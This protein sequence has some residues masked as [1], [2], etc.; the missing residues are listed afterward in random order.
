[1]KHYVAIGEAS[2]WIG[3]CIK[4]L[5]R[6]DQDGKIHYYRTLGGH[7]RF[8]LIEIERIISGDLTEEV[9][10]FGMSESLS[11]S[12][13]AIYARVSSHEQKKKGDL[14][15]QIE[16][17]K[18]YCEERGASSPRVFTDVSSGLNTKRSGLMRLFDSRQILG[19]SLM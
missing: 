7:R 17:A 5:R 18:E 13:T 15:R 4:T 10:M 14:D 1:M 16:T 19:A 11:N 6:W 8:A 9:R 2:K 3:V 12:K